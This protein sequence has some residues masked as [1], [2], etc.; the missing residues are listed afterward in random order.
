MVSEALAGFGKKGR[1]GECV[2][3]HVRGSLFCVDM[4]SNECSFSYGE[5]C[6]FIHEG[7]PPTSVQQLPRR[8]DYMMNSQQAHGLR[9]QSPMSQSQLL[10][11]PLPGRTSSRSVCRYWLQ[12]ICNRGPACRFLH[13]SAAPAAMGAAAAAIDRNGSVTAARP[14]PRPRSAPFLIQSLP[15]SFDIQ[16]P[17][18]HHL[19]MGPP[20]RF[21]TFTHPSLVLPAPPPP[22]SLTLNYL[23]IETK[24]PVPR[25]A[26]L[27]RMPTQT[28]SEDE[29]ALPFDLDEWD[30][31]DPSAV[32]RRASGGSSSNGG[33][34]MEDQGGSGM[35]GLGTAEIEQGVERLLL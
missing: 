22:E 18:Q 3:S 17:Q 32:S 14:R 6:W 27:Q 20:T 34:L 19:T 2:L 8:P 29:M 11:Q 1:A 28:A 30:D 33:L 21:R 9:G 35:W 4:N 12:G 25:P 16:P 7:H 10:P 24:F 13:G 5:T 23:D 26:P 31:F 15:P